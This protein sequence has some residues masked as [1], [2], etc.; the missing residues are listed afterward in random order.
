MGVDFSGLSVFRQSS[1]R[2][3]IPATALRN[4]RS[5]VAG[6]SKGKRKISEVAGIDVPRRWS[7]D[8]VLS[9]DRET[10]CGADTPGRSFYPAG[11]Y[12]QNY[13]ALN[14][15]DRYIVVNDVPTVAHLRSL[16]PQR[17]REQPVLVGAQAQ[18]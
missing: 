16:F 12:H 2:E 3:R 13:V 8:S 17:Y 11:A 18:L 6:K 5:S 4:L 7:C 10:Y 15:T 9:R 1:A 14:P